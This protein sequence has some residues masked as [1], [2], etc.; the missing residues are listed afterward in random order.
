MQASNTEQMQQ[1]NRK[2]KLQ[3]SNAAEIK[4]IINH[5]FVARH[6]KPKKIKNKKKHIRRNYKTDQT[7]TNQI[8][9]KLQL[10]TPHQNK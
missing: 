10:S 4:Q 6:R 3:S 2:N 9:M 1:S 8:K 7:S 5:R